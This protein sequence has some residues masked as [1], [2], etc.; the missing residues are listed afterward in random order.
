MPVVTVVQVDL[1]RVFQKEC[2]PK[3][4][5]W[6]PQTLKIQIDVDKAL[7]KK[8]DEDSLLQ[9]KLW[10][11]AS[12]PYK[13]FIAKCKADFTKT[14]AELQTIR[15]KIAD[16]LEA[17]QPVEKAMSRLT[18]NI[19]AYFEELT[20][21]V[22]KAVLAEWN[23]ITAKNKGYRIYKIKAF[24]SCALRV[25]AMV[26]AAVAL[27]NPFTA[28]PAILAIQTIVSGCASVLQDLAKLA[29]SANKFRE[30]V[31]KEILKLA[32]AYKKSGK[33]KVSAAEFGKSSFKT[34]F[35]YEFSTVAT[36]QKS[37]G[38]YRKKLVG[39]DQ[40]SHKTA[41]DLNKVLREMDTV[42]KQGPQSV[43][44]DLGTLEGIVDKLI[45]DVIGLQEQ[46]KEGESWADK[47][48]P[49]LEELGK[50]KY[51]AVTVV[52]KL[53]AT[54][55]AASKVGIDYAKLADLAESGS[56]QAGHAIKAANGLYHSYQMWEKKAKA[57]SGGRA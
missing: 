52:E 37:V 29:R 16:P 18:H 43:K 34:I 57:A 48:Q 46:V 50:K 49:L 54:A 47:Q 45:K 9:A 28:G 2:K 22:P 21:D 39:V 53:L 40:K 6:E 5:R 51:A 26:A 32:A 12:A 7:H 44:K 1:W 13:K 10:E 23:K 14:D 30:G 56:K 24:V 19:P 8:L 15:R 17:Q 35:G 38:Q 31:N 20:R 33:V 25:G 4:I 36:C 27:S 3:C 41:K 11:A 42:R 55:L